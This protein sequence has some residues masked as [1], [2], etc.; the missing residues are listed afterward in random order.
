MSSDDDSQKGYRLSATDTSSSRTGKKID[1]TEFLLTVAHGLEERA[2]WI[3][4]PPGQVCYSATILQFY[5]KSMIDIP[6]GHESAL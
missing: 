2:I 1:S 5:Y 6:V 3:H 4:K